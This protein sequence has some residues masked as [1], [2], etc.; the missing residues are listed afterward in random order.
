MSDRRSIFCVECGKDV[1]ARLTSGTEIYPHRSDLGWIPF[2][3]HDVCGNYVGCH[4]KTANRTAPLGCIPTKELMEKRKQI[5]AVIDK[6]WKN[7]NMKR[8]AVYK[9]IGKKLGR[10]HPYHTAGIRNMAEAERVLKAAGELTAE[11]QAA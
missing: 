4:H 2:W 3:I 7:G 9:A 6:L 11:Q 8:S 1:E 5:H 10:K